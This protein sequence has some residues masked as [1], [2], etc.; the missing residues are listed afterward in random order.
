ARA[1]PR[2]RRGEARGAHA[3]ARTRAGRGA[4]APRRARRLA[5]RG[6][7]AMTPSAPAP[8]TPAQRAAGLAKEL[9]A[10]PARTLVLACLLE[11]A[12]SIALA[13]R[14]S[15]EPGLVEEKS[16]VFDAELGWVA[17]KSFRAA[18]LF[19]EGRS[20]TTNAR[21][22]RGAREV[23]DEIPAGRYRIVCVGDS[24]TLGY[25]VGDE[26]TYEAYLERALP[27]LETVNMGQGGYGV[28]Q[29]Y[30]WYLR[31]GRSLHADLLLLAAIA[32]DWERM[33]D[34][35]FQGEFPKPVLE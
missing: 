34:A 6:A 8:R 33:L 7:R 10:S 14:D 16:C 18:N 11:G 27:A 19:G 12:L 9:A 32:P 4:R 17:R 30:L 5:A 15:S 31:D 25:G 23:D 20:L 13:W 26:S 29:A 22:F 21:G 28:D 35:R 1:R 2:R 24:F 3:A